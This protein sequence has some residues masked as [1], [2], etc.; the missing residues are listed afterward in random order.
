MLAQAF[1]EIKVHSIC[2]E[3]MFFN[4]AKMVERKK[5]LEQMC[6]ILDESEKRLEKYS[7]D[8]IQW[9]SSAPN[10]DDQARNK[11]Q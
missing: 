9:L 3:E 11:I 10:L 2:T 7:S 1:A 5:R 4:L 6:I 8:C